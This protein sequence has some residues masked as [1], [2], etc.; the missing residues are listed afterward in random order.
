MHP[1]NHDI[2]ISST[3][4]TDH[5][6]QVEITTQLS[7]NPTIEGVD[8]TEYVSFE[9]NELQ[10]TTRKPEQGVSEVATAITYAD[11]YN[12]INVDRH[13]RANHVATVLQDAPAIIDVTYT[14]EIP[15]LCV[16]HD[17]LRSDYYDNVLFLGGLEENHWWISFDRDNGL[18]LTIEYR[19]SQFAPVV[20]DTAWEDLHDAVKNK[21][22]ET[23]LIPTDSFCTPLVL[24]EEYDGTQ[25]IVTHP[26][27][28]GHRLAGTLHS[29]EH[30]YYLVEYRDADIDQVVEHVFLDLSTDE[31]EF[32]VSWAETNIPQKEL[33]K[34]AK[35]KH[36]LTSDDTETQNINLENI[37]QW[38]PPQT[39]DT[40]NTTYTPLTNT[41]DTDTDK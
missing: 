9:D 26:D 25:D 22:R 23:E 35:E 4:D 34:Y 21:T 27:I 18:T 33:E 8:N 29:A 14:P 40:E 13:S 10:Y 6:S 12:G 31:V 15:E 7:G 28:T 36:A 24:F 16:T 32:L 3:T 20:S 30:A 5:S 19:I 41:E 37:D 39:R 38:T 11:T 1:Y 2:S 17:T